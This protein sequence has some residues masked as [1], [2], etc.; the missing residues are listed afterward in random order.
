MIDPS[1]DIK[2]SVKQIDDL[3]AAI[4]ATIP[5]GASN[6]EKFKALRDYLYRPPLV[7]GRQPYLYNFQD[8]R[9]LRAKLLPVYLN[10]RRGNC[11]SMPTLFVILGQKLGIPVALA[12]APEHLYLKFRGDNGLWYGVE[13][14]NGG[15]WADDAWQRKN[16]PSITPESIANGVYLQPLTRKEAAVV[17]IDSL[18]EQYELQ[19]SDEADE[20]RIKLALLLVEHYPKDMVAILHAYLGYKGLRQRQFIEKY[21]R[22]SDIPVHMRR[23]FEQLSDGWQYWGHR[24]KALGFKAPTAAE[25]AA[26]RER[27]KQARA[28]IDR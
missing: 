11:V 14:T 21:P 8:D 5:A 20:A 25:Q 19:N 4:R 17:A 9:S 28:G 16:F 26:Y 18:L 7:G 24:A 6:L 3:A 2:A 13:A 27:I 1:L 15:G 10:T 12:S 22:P 23:R